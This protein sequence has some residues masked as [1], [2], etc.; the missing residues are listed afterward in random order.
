MA[1][2]SIKRFSAY[3]DAEL[4]ESLHRYASNSR[5]AHVSS[6][7]FSEATGIAEATVTNHFGSWR[8]FCSK[9]GLA[10]R[11]QRTVSHQSLFENLEHVWQ[12][13]GR[14]PRAKEMKQPLSSISISRYQK[15]FNEP[16]HRVCLR[17]LSW[18]SGAPTS[19]IER[20]AVAP[21]S[22]AQ[23]SRASRR[24]VTLSLRYAVLKRDGFRCVKCGASPATNRAV[25]LH[26]DHVIAWANGGQ[27]ALS[28][29]QSLCSNCNLGKSNRHDG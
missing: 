5:V 4:L 10:P 29:L 21:P 18:E 15:E 9:A 13:L 14:Q 12:Y 27:T 24:G 6:R 22:S 16:W 28:N 20:E 8:E 23:V 19:E 25:Q 2:Y 17:F 26:V 3:S 1:D 7:A 11:Y